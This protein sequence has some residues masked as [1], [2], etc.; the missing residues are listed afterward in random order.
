MRRGR[1]HYR[2]PKARIVKFDEG[3]ALIYQTG[4]AVIMGPRPEIVVIKCIQVLTDAGYIPSPIPYF[5]ETNT[6]I[7]GSVGSY[8]DLNAMQ[9]AN[10]QRVFFEP[11]LHNSAVVRLSSD[12]R[13]KLVM[14]ASGKFHLTGAVYYE[15]I[16]QLLDHLLT[17]HT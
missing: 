12:S 14:F 11:E 16:P 6:I 4:G 8:V 3:T 15:G 7:C 5:R 1:M 2:R 10:P 9:R 13:A 17:K